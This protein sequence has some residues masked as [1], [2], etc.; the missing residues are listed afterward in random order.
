MEKDFN[1]I[2]YVHLSNRLISYRKHIL[3]K[4]NVSEEA[5]DSI[6]SKKLWDLSVE[7]CD[8]FR[9]TLIDI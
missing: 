8:S 1:D 5:N 2:K 9:I 4:A 7:I 3:K 6:L